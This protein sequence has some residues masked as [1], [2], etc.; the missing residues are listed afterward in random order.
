MLQACANAWTPVA[1]PYAR[2]DALS[3]LPLPTTHEIRTSPAILNQRTG[4]T[5][6]AVTPDVVAKFGQG[7]AEREGQTLLYLESHAPDVP[8]PRLYAMYYDAGDL[9]V[10][11]QRIPGMRL[12]T[13]WETLSEEEKESVTADLRIIFDD[14]RR[15]HCPW[16]SYYGAID[17]GPVPHPLFYS[18]DGN[19]TI[20]GPFDSEEKFNLGL[21]A[22]YKR[23]REMNAGTDFKSYFYSNY[24]GDVLHGHKSTLTHGDVQR[25]NIIVA[26]KDGRQQNRSRKFEL[27]LVDWE[28]AGRYPEYWEYF[29]AFAGF[30]WNDDWCERFGHFIPAWPA[31]AVMVKMI[32]S[33]LFF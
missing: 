20:S 18:H 25:K 6:V 27:A 2:N 7:T 28:D 4:Q 14:L 30:R 11:M 33:D 23:M 13:L 12:D 32:Y 29:A 31:E 3:P 17:G 22:Q 9:F 15:A 19:A 10:V 16:P 1:L 24:L 8:A 26:E 5:V 21:I